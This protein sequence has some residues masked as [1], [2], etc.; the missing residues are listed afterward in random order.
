MLRFPV[1]MAFAL[2]ACAIAPIATGQPV[3]DV[4]PVVA[5]D[6]LQGR[7]TITA[8]NGRQVSGLWLELGGE[9]FAKITT[10]R[11]A[12]FVASPQPL[13][14]AFLGCNDL[15][16]SGWTRKGD[17]LTL[18]VQM[19]HR[20]ERGCDP[21]RE[22]VDDEAYAILRKTVTMEFTPPNHLRL[23]NEIGTLDLDRSG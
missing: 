16:P 18:G 20:T 15:Y 23:I 21:V 8:V 10:T 5:E 2:G 11:N 14:K 13:T 19:S 1:F 3:A 7:Y 22:S 9:G 12:V 4:G 6:N 17:K